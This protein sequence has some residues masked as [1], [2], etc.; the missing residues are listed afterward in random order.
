MQKLRFML[1]LAIVALCSTLAL[2]NNIPVFTQGVAIPA[3]GAD[4]Q[5]FFTFSIGG[6]IG[7]ALLTTTDL[8]GGH[9]LAT[10]GTLDVTAGAAVG[11]YSLSLGGPAPFI[12]PSGAF[13][14]DNVLTPAADPILDTYGLLFGSGGVEINIWGNSPGNY[15]FYSWTGGSYVVSTTGP[16]AVTATAVPEPTTLLLLGSGL[17]GIAT[18]TSRKITGRP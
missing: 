6:N 15:S 5:Y 7:S 18:M 13:Q 14:V 2:A 17:I 3:T 11:T 4:P 8:G 16:G 1:L 12:S 10:G 9:S